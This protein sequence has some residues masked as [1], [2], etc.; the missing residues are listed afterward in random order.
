[1]SVLFRRVL[2]CA[3]LAVMLIGLMGC[4]PPAPVAAQFV[5]QW[6]SSRMTAAPLHLYANGEW[7]I[8]AP[9]DDKVMQFGV[10]EVKHSS[11]IWYVKLN[12]RLERDSNAIVSLA[13][14]RFELRERDGSITRF[15]RLH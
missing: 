9:D 10:W 6:R 7:E 15:E 4:S 2:G 13:K 11:F 5:G 8:R 1:M 14:D 12:G 3:F